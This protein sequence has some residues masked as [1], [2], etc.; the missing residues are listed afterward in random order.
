MMDKFLF[1]EEIKKTV[2]AYGKFLKEHGVLKKEIR[3]WDE[4]PVISK[5][6][7]LLKYRVE[8]TVR[9]GE[10]D[11]CFLIGASSGFSKKGSVF[12]LKGAVDEDAYLNA[13]EEFFKQ[14]YSIDRK[15]T[16]II[17][18]LAFGTW[19]GGIQIA[20]TMRQLAVKTGYPLT[21]TFPGL[22]LEE[23]ALIVKRFQKSFDQILWI[24]N[25]SNIPIIYSLL[26][27]DADLLNG[28][29]FFPVVGEYFTEN[30]RENI[31]QKFGH[32]RDEESV[33]WTGYG[34]ADTGDL[35]IESKASIALRKFFL[36]NPDLCKAV[37]N[38]E[39]VPMILE[40]SSDAFI[41]ILDQNIIV[42]KDQ[43]IPLVRYNTKDSGGLLAK[44]VL[45]GKIPEPL[46][47]RLPDKLLYVFGRVSDSI[48]FYGTNLKIPEI[49]N[50][51]NALG[52]EYKYS[53]LFEIEEKEVDG[54]TIFK[55]TVYT[56]DKDEGKE[57]AYRDA[58]IRFLK[59]YSREF[60]AKYDNLVKSSKQELIQV[61]IAAVGEKS[62][63]T[64]HRFIKE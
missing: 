38:S 6:N 45:T 48:I 63:V 30:Y 36:R 50:F 3:N 43:L 16:L 52:K 20:C 47:S 17:V 5:E 2:P 61:A 28:K 13:L 24:T 33:L 19:I 14:F 27:D 18:S 44:S 59:S 23:G 57:K 55:F 25:G 64:K 9:E 60:N 49:N 1:F 15:K 26:K 12:W 22:D 8:E 34:S 7:Y 42:T 35:G 41:E 54:I 58:L 40:K 62:S 56:D 53:G 39:D 10:M 32:K 4:I 21:S 29:V 31:A 11:K 46:Y 37:F 51:L